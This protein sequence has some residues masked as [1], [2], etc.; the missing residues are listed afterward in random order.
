MIRWEQEV[1]GW[2]GSSGEL[3]VAKVV[4]DVESERESWN[5]QVTQSSGR[6][7]GVS[8]LGTAQHRSTHGALCGRVLGEMAHRHGASTRRGPTGAWEPSVGG[9]QTTAPREVGL[10][11]PAAARRLTYRELCD[12]PASQVARVR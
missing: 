9:G 5:W 4:K 10:I 6:T 1:D 11:M 12:F 7:A 3:P 8:P 2:V